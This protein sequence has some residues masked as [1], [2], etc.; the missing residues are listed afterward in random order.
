AAVTDRVEI[1]TG[2]VNVYSRTAA[3]MAMTAAGCDYVSDGRFILGLG[4]S[5]PQVIEGFHGVK[6]EKPMQRIKEYI[7]ACRMI[8]KR[9]EKFD[10]QGQT[11]QA[12][13]P[14]G[15]GTGLGKPLKL[16]NHPVRPDIPIWWASLKGLSVTA[17]AEMADG[18]L[19]I[20]FIPEKFHL[21]WGDQL[22]AGLAKRDPSLPRLDIAA[23]GMLA[24]GE[25]LVGDKQAEILDF[26]RPTTALY[27]GGMG[28]R[29][30]NF[31]ND[32][33][34]DYGYEQE[35]VDIQDL[36]LDGKKDQAAAR[37]PGEW[38]ELSHLVGPVG[39]IKDRVGAYKE[40]GVTVLSVN[41]VGPDAVKQIETL[42]AIVDDA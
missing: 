23:G 42:R 22:K 27:V 40:A 9:E 36:Y 18:W 8:W 37:V 31:Y 4:A 7:E 20:M 34:R 28:A 30:K 41:P 25:D 38:L 21:V 1:G 32:I 15:E 33:C 17:T 10:Y 12:P 16:I 39:Y 26:A 14:P 29:G 3:L 5:G 19:P 35:A 13:L 2:I 11:F 6:Y 24:I